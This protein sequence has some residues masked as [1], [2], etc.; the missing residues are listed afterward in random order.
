MMVEHLTNEAPYRFRCKRGEFENF[1]EHLDPTQ[2]PPT[3]AAFGG[4]LVALSGDFTERKVGDRRFVDVKHGGTIWTYEL[5]HAYRAEVSESGCGIYQWPEFF[6]V[7][8]W[9]D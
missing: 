4:L 8:W 5:E 9:V 6:D 1:P 7:G 2:P 3:I